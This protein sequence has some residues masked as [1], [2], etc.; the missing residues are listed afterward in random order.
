LRGFPL[1]LLWYSLAP[2]RLAPWWW[3]IG[4]LRALFGCRRLKCI[5]LILRQI[6][7]FLFFGRCKLARNGNGGGEIEE[8]S[9]WIKA[10]PNIG[11]NVAM[12]S[13]VSE[14]EK[15]KLTITEKN[16]FI[17]KNLNRY[18]DNNEQWIPDEIYITAFRPVQMPP[19]GTR[20][21]AYMGIDLSSQRDLAAT[22]IHWVDEATGR[23]GVIPEF[24]FPQNETK[25]VRNSGIDLGEWIEKNHIIEHPTNTID[26]KIILERIKYWNT[27]FEI[28]Q[29]NYDE[30]NSGFIIPEIE[31]SLY[32]TCCKFRQNTTWFNFPLKYIEKLFFDDTLDMGKNPVMRWMFRNIVLYKD[33]NGNIKIMKNKSQDSVD[34]PVAWA[35]AV[36]AWLQN[37]NDITADFFKTLMAP[38]DSE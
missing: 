16:N 35:M 30:W 20:P 1:R 6:L 9:T 24:H 26:Q 18:L 3:R 8:Y 12:E 36:G 4:M 37:N 32:I 2:A 34:G 33:G 21:V 14:W 10:N 25:K 31:S 5:A 28:R 17:T 38:K 11:V 7:F 23:H 19:A 13:L 15:A 29:I 27:I 22:V